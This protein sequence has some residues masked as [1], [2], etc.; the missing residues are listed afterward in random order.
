MNLNI[1]HKKEYSKIL[2][3]LSRL[4]RIKI[5]FFEFINIIF[6]NVLL[7]LFQ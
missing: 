4:T 1:I 3:Y 7:I 6:Y 2:N 5:N